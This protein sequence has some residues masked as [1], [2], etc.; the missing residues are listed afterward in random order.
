M[1]EA[2]RLPTLGKVSEALVDEWSLEGCLTGHQRE[3]FVGLMDRLT[4]GGPL[5]LTPEEEELLAELPDEG[6]VAV[7]RPP[8]ITRQR[9]RWIV[10]LA[11]LPYS[12]G[13]ICRTIGVS[14]SVLKEARR[15][16]PGL[17]AALTYAR[18]VWLARIAEARERAVEVA[19]A[20]GD[21]RA[22]VQDQLDE[23][24]RLATEERED[25]WAD[26]G[27][28]VALIAERLQGMIGGDGGAGPAGGLRG[29]PWSPA[30]ASCGGC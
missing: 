10:A 16:H 28:V 6:R 26:S 25:P 30:R 9:A 4:R 11:K 19:I 14:Y 17:L 3:L 1:A 13:G 15:D 22:A 29:P 20:T 23:R 5:A 27:E 8:A 18:T 21:W 24:R 2:A 7:G 12:F